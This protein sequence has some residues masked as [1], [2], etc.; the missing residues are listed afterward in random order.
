MTT[1]E[2]DQKATELYEHLRR[3]ISGC[4]M[5]ETGHDPGN[6][7]EPGLPE[8]SNLGQEIIW[9]C[10]NGHL[11]YMDLLM[12][13]TSIRLEDREISILSAHMTPL[14]CIRVVPP[15]QTRMEGAPHGLPTFTLRAYNTGPDQPW[16]EHTGADEE[17]REAIQG[18][19]EAVIYAR[20]APRVKA[21]PRVGRHQCRHYHRR[22]LLL[23][24][25]RGR[26]RD[27]PVAG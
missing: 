3:R 27:A 26:R 5:C 21:K 11:H 16:W 18:F 8:L 24:G 20:S 13:A 6:H 23:R 9:V 14:F 12:A 22:R 1:D 2:L 19:T 17:K 15:E 4:S 10:E 7:T 25:M